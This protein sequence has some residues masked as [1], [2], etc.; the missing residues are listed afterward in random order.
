[1]DLK[2]SISLRLGFSC[3][4]ALRPASPRDLLVLAPMKGSKICTT[5]SGS[6]PWVLG[7]KLRA[8]C[9]CSKKFY[10]LS[11]LPCPQP[12]VFKEV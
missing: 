3:S 10:L 1:M 7:I 12:Y 6:V 2:Y 11:H 4:Q 5:T 9:L 8:S